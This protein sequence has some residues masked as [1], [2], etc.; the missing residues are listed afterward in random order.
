MLRVVDLVAESPF[1]PL[2]I[3]ALLSIV[4]GGSGNNGEE[5]YDDLNRYVVEPVDDVHFDKKAPEAL[6][7]MMLSLYD[8]AALKFGI[9][10]NPHPLGVLLYGPPSTGKTLPTSN[11]GLWVEDINQFLEEIDGIKSNGAQNP[12][13]IA[14]TNKPFDVDGGILRHLTRQIMIDMPEAVARDRILLIHMKE[15]KLADDVVVVPEPV[16]V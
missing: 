2:Y 7:I 11:Q 4:N 1:L 13:A 8:P 15:E 9:L 10:A 6:D 5:T 3:N 12:V 16:K 14:A